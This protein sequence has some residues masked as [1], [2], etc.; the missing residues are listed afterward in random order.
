[1]GRVRSEL[2]E[3][4]GGKWVGCGWAVGYH[5]L[6]MVLHWQLWGVFVMGLS[7]LRCSF[8]SSLLICHQNI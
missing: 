5:S 6:C 4:V 8:F 3:W 7:F 1:M 2:C